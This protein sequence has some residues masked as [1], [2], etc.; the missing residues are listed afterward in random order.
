MSSAI[1]ATPAALM[2][3]RRRA[4]LDRDAEAFA[5]LFAADAVID[6]PFAGSR[7]EQIR[8]EGRQTI[9]EYAQRVMASPLQ[10]EDFD[11]TALHQTRDPDVVIAEV[12]T[13]GTIG[14]TGRPF[15]VTSVQILHL[16]DGLI[17]LFR[18]YADPRL[19]AEV[20]ADLDHTDTTPAA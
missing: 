14:A 16:R 7:D 5:A 17:T 15:T 6:L 1:S 20:M 19:V 10:L 8:M 13:R 4:I 2:D 11:V 3:R 18:D 9:L 12:R